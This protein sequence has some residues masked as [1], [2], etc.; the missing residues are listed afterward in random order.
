MSHLS[1]LAP[2]HILCWGAP[3][4]FI[5]CRHHLPHHYWVGG[6]GKEIYAPKVARLDLEPKWPPRE[7]T[8]PSTYTTSLS[9]SLTHA[10]LDFYDSSVSTTTQPTGIDF[11][12]LVGDVSSVLFGTPTH[13][14]LGCP[15]QIYNLPPPL[16]SAIA[17]PCIW[18]MSP[19]RCSSRTRSG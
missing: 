4:R 3:F 12:A 11:E 16:T 2:P 5:T 15:F 9:C 13:P 7:L 1:F 17:R 8:Q 6:C 14:V 18:H 10:S 19:P